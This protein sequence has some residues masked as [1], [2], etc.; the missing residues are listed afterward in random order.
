[1]AL[2][3]ST[4]AV[5]HLLAIAN[6]ARV[7]LA[8][9]RLQPRGRARA[10]P[11]RHE[12]AREVPHDRPRP[13]RRRPRR[14]ARSSWTHGLLHGDCLT[15]T[16]K[17][18]AENLAALD[19]PAPDG[20][21]VH[22]PLPTRSTPTG[23]IAVLR[24]SLAPEGRGRQG[25]RDRRDS[26]SP[27]PPASS[28]A[29]TRRWR[30]S[31][32][33]RSSPGPVVVIRYEGP[34]GGPGMRE[35]LAVTGRHEGRRAGA[36]TARWSPTGASPAAP[37]ASASATSLPRRPSADRSRSCATATRSCWTPH[38]GR[39]TC[40]S[41]PDELERRRAQGQAPR[42]PLHDGR[43]RQVRPPGRRGRAGRGHRGLAAVAPPVWHRPGG[44]AR[45]G[46]HLADR[47]PVCGRQSRSATLVG[48]DRQRPASVLVT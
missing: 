14:A 31:W 39:S 42:P 23:G 43:A 10:A 41:T 45:S 30:P 18:M 2:G 29:R 3:G 27:A 20:D 5:L 12:A 36:A 7:E 37:R 19:P 48:D 34:K 13:D 8:P 35:M 15:V 46:R 47:H 33:A 6:E 24:G 26:P 16:G 32:P 1:M 11:R 9:G 17:T 40:S 28:T 4:N 21:V 22:V 25:R 38:Q 44:W